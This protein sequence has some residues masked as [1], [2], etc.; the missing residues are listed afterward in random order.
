MTP[1]HTFVSFVAEEVQMLEPQRTQGYTK[2][3]TARLDSPPTATTRA[4]RLGKSARKLQKSPSK[5]FRDCRELS[6]GSDK[7][8]RGTSV[9]S[10]TPISEPQLSPQLHAL[11]RN[12]LDLSRQHLVP[13]KA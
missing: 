13:S 8:R 3:R 7:R 4:R 2:E 10:I 5:L 11:E 9:G 1:L 12:Q 6:D